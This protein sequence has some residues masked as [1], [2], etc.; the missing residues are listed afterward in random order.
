MALGKWHAVIKNHT[1]K[2]KNPSQKC[3]LRFDRKG[4]VL[5]EDIVFRLE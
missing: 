4:K 5:G 2:K 3:A 1:G